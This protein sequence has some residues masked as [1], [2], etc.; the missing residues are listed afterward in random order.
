MHPVHSGYTV[1]DNADWV[2]ASIVQLGVGLVQHGSVA[3]F[4][5][6]LANKGTTDGTHLCA[7]Y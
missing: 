6:D 3:I 1:A 2:L 7:K 5:F 4:L